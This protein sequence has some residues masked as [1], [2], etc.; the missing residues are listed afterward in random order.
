[1]NEAQWWWWMVLAAVFAIGEMITAGFFLFWF[2]VGALLAG[3][4]AWLGYG[5][6]WQLLIFV[7]S[8]G[9]L[10]ALSRRFAER[11]TRKQPDGVGANRFYGR[12]T[13][14]LTEIDNIKGVGSVRLDREEWRASSAD[15]EVIPAGESVVVDSVD[16]TRLIVKRAAA[17]E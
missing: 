7:V 3:L 16:G 2:A 13:V 9:V 5:P 10:F 14:V 4:L 12:Q 6:Q 17:K 1:M 8:S 11:F 15:G